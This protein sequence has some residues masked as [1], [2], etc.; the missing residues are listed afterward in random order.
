MT[1]QDFLS[2]FD[3]S[4]IGGHFVYHT[5]YLF[6]DRFEKDKTTA[7]GHVADLAWSM[8]ENGFICLVQRRVAKFKYEYIAIRRKSELAKR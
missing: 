6:T 2:W 5:G 7:V 8:Y 4:F 1:E 3:K